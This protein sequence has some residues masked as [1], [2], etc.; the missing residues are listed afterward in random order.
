[1]GPD[2]DKVVISEENFYGLN[3]SPPVHFAQAEEI[4]FTPRVLHSVSPK[5]KK[6]GASVPQDMDASSSK[7][8]SPI[9]PPP[10]RASELPPGM[11]NDMLGLALKRSGASLSSI[12]QPP[13]TDP[14]D[15][16]P[17]DRLSNVLERSNKLRSY[18]VAIKSAATHGL[19]K[20]QALVAA[21]KAEQL[22]SGVPVSGGASV[23]SG[24][25]MEAG[26]GGRSWGG[27]SA[28][29]SSSSLKPTLRLSSDPS[30]G[31]GSLVGFKEDPYK[32]KADADKAAIA[33]LLSLLPSTG[34]GSNNI[35]KTLSGVTLERSTDVRNLWGKGEKVIRVPPPPKMLSRRQR[36]ALEAKSSS[37][38][39]SEPN[40]NSRKNLNT[41][42]KNA[43]NLIESA[44]RRPP[45][46]VD[47]GE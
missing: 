9:L 40:S 30:T 35:I 45:N 4:A 19:R 13:T 10:P 5:S 3:K 47:L 1:M 12:N 26:T 2:L 17:E 41:S 36:E 46:N 8:R 6:S 18:A 42:M 34:V 27:S 14:K 24:N 23:V 38:A 20:V 29:S 32:S 7:Q 44:S 33:K 28:S 15:M 22:Q 37:A 31:P 21:Q 39:D 16:L 43:S 11:R 25:A